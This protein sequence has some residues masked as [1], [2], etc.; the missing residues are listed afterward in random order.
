MENKEAVIVSVGENPCFIR[1]DIVDSLIRVTFDSGDVVDIQMNAGE[2]KSGLGAIVTL[3]DEE[4]YDDSRQDLIDKA[5]EVAEK[6]EK[7][8]IETGFTRV[9]LPFNIPLNNRD[10]MLLIDNDDGAAH[11]IAEGHYN[12]DYSPAFGVIKSF[13][14]KE[15]AL[16]FCNSFK[17]NEYH[18]FKGLMDMLSSIATDS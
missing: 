1:E 10:Y 13:I 17:T 8:R 15:E 5:I 2:Y 9:D 14:D 12:D 6:H 11:L 7:E 18:D 16:K 3:N 4:D